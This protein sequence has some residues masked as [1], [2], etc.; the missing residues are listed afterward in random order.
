LSVTQDLTSSI[1][2]STGNT[3]IAPPNASFTISG[4]EQYIKSGWL[5]AKT[6]EK[7]YP[8]S[9]NT[10]RVAFQKSGTYIFVN[11]T[12]DDRNG[13]GKVA[14]PMDKKGQLIFYFY[15]QIIHIKDL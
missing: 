15:Y 13:N 7:V 8:G 12:H 14:Q 10:F 4:N 6:Q 3:K 11:C 1:I 2:D 5:V 9:S